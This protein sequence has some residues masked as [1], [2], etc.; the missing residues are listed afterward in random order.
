MSRRCAQ[1]G[2]PIPIDKPTDTVKRR[3]TRDGYL[4]TEVVLLHKGGCPRWDA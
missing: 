2:R 1:C 4:V 3:Y